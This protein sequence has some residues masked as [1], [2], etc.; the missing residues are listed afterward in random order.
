MC[1]FSKIGIG[2]RCHL[3]IPI[4]HG[5][6]TLTCVWYLKTCLQQGLVV[7]NSNRAWL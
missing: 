4:L 1:R 7:K 3:L 5:Q 2:I 6:T